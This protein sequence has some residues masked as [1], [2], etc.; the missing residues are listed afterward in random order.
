MNKDELLFTPEDITKALN[1]LPSNTGLDIMRDAH[2]LSS[3]IE[4]ITIEDALILLA[5][6]GAYPKQKRM[7]EIK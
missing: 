5:E 7:K 2:T 3:K 4:G 1:N 6:I